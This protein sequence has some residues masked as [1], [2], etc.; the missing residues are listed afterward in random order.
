M[1]SMRPSSCHNCVSGRHLHHPSED[2]IVLTRVRAWAGCRLQACG[3][4]RAGTHGVHHLTVPVWGPA[5]GTLS[6]H[7]LQALCERLASR[8]AVAAPWPGGDRDRVRGRPA[9]D[10]GVRRREDDARARSPGA[11]AAGVHCG[12]ALARVLRSRRSAR[13]KRGTLVAPC[14]VLVRLPSRQ[15]GRELAVTGRGSGSTG[16]TSACGLA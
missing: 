16:G 1:P 12:G 9:H 4:A 10:A 3:A 13:A 8:F 7:A 11:K 14:F 15:R 2:G 6:Q 5:A